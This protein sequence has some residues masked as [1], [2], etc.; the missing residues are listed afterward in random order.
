MRGRAA[1]A[2]ALALASCAVALASCAERPP[3][4][5]E[6]RRAAL[7]GAVVAR[8]GGDEI[9][10]ELV[11]A[12][13]KAQGI[14]P[15]AALDALVADALAAAGARERGLDQAQPASF[16]VRA[17]RA[18]LVADALAADARRA[19]P[20]SDDELA[21]ATLRHWQAVDRGETLRVLH[22]LA[23][24]SRKNPAAPAVIEETARRMRAAVADAKDAAEFSQRAKAVPRP[25]GV[26]VVV[27]EL[28]PFT[29]D[30]WAAEGTGRMAEEFTRGAWALGQVGATSQPVS[31]PFGWHVILLLE[32]IPPRRMSAEER[33]IALAD[34][35]Y[36][37]RAKA[38]AAQVVAR[39]RAA[40]KIE[41]SP[42]AQTL[43]ARV[44]AS[45][46]AE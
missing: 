41:V 6:E 16:R 37:E 36:G 12:V 14:S 2:V 33:R 29:D 20:P 44:F 8:V 40:T 25:P 32:R 26:D 28:P 22:A 43:T 19:G 11:A 24:P 35:I 31:S 17:A 42:A 21:A 23:A 39:A 10:L 1:W 15:E 45:K 13:S 3:S 18:R 38:A 30:G 5:G 4:P 7:G 9:P 34:E 46:G 27:E